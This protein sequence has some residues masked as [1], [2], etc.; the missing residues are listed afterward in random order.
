MKVFN[1][2]LTC[3][4]IVLHDSLWAYGKLYDQATFDSNLAQG[5]P[6]LIHVHAAWCS[7]CRAQ[8]MILDELMK[9]GDYPTIEV[10]QVNFDERKDLLDK[11]MV[12]YQSTLILF[13]GGQEIDRL[14]T[15]RNVS[16]IRKLLDQ[17]L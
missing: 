12:D 13:K 3:V 14:S 6:T 15:K 11:F 16:A 8:D 9:S 2:I 5:K 17:S 10:L 1:Y 4:F 7:T